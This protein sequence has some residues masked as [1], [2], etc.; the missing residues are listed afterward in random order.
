MKCP[1]L[2]RNVTLTFMKHKLTK[3]ISILI[4]SAIASPDAAYCR[5]DS[6][7]RPV[8][9][10]EK[11]IRGVIPAVDTERNYTY[12]DLRI[13]YHLPTWFGPDWSTLLKDAATA[14]GTSFYRH[15]S[16]QS[17][18]DAFNVFIDEM[19]ELAQSGRPVRI[20]SAG[21]STGQEA[22]TIA[23]ELLEKG[24]PAEKIHIVGI[25]KDA[26]LI[27]QA[28]AG[29]YSGEEML[30]DKDMPNRIKVKY[31]IHPAID[32]Y[33]ACNELRRIVEFQVCDVCD[34]DTMGRLGMF[35]GVIHNQPF[36]G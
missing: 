5:V 6:I 23:I 12:E 34:K 2:L 21:C 10:G 36:F 9:A 29:I 33:R 35:D 7:L 22:Y 13:L 30:A 16:F 24:A 15:T 28:M 20:L 17:E 4:I 3:L 14:T 19:A 25:D 31:F 26:M 32:T 27:K 11:N 8:A 18:R 1:D